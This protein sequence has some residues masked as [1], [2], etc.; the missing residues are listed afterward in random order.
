MPVQITRNILLHMQWPPWSPHKPVCTQC[1]EACS[2]VPRE[3]RNGLKVLVGCWSFVAVARIII[4]YKSIS[5]NIII[6]IFILFMLVIEVIASQIGGTNSPRSPGLASCFQVFIDVAD[7]S[8]S[9]WHCITSSQFY[10]V[11]IR[12]TKYMYDFV[13]LMNSNTSI[14]QRMIF[15]FMC[16]RHVPSG[17]CW[18]VVYI[19]RFFFTNFEMRVLLISRLMLEWEGWARKPVN[20]NS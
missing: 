10:I 1:R 14:P 6:H 13:V 16:H 12:T 4:Y 2:R 7:V 17:G 8:L 19:R 3:S 5:H 11:V 18:F 15:F 9:Q 20:H